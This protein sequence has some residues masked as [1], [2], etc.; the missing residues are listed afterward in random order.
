MSE[1]R[2]N[3]LNSYTSL[4]NAARGF[5]DAINQQL[6]DRK[7]TYDFWKMLGKANKEYLNL[8]TTG[9]GTF[10]EFLEYNYGIR[11]YEDESGNYKAQYDKVDEQLYL[12]FTLKF[13]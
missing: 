5:T 6:S 13:S 2:D 3:E 10:K 4:A 1:Y 9:E 11:L 12:F 7:D 8:D